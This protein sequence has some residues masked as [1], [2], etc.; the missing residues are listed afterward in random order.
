MAPVTLYSFFNKKPK[1]DVSA[2]LP[3]SNAAA[4]TTPTV[5][6][7]PENAAAVT[8]DRRS[9]YDAITVGTRLS[10]HWT[11][12]QIF[13]PATVRE[14]KESRVHLQY[15]HGKWE[16]VDLRTEEYQLLSDEAQPS[17]EPKASS[18][19]KHTASDTSPDDDDDDDD[20]E[21]ELGDVSEAEDMEDDQWMLSDDEE[22]APAKKK[23]TKRLKSFQVTE[24]R[25]P[26]TGART[27]S[28]QSRGAAR[29]NSSLQHLR[30][31]PQPV[32]TTPRPPGAPR[33]ATSSQGAASCTI[34]PETTTKSNNP[35]PYTKGEVNPA[36]SHV[37]NHLKFF[38]S[39]RDA[40]GRPRNHPDYNPRTLQVKWHELEQQGENVTPARQQWWQIKSDYFDTVLLFKTGKLER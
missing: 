28:T 29:P 36:G 15:D 35:L 32:F 31:T 7:R 12:D 4:A 23:T 34:T 38:Q 26:S 30:A 39:P 25:P 24:H 14:K 8:A 11:L 16:W 10:V 6:R 3:A 1:V 9:K 5:A 27:P 40:Q 21:F 17:E 22:T 18:K 33:M 20:E 2:S 19:R 37:H 13:Y